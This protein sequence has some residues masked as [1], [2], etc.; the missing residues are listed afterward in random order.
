[1]PV[2]I[3]IGSRY[4]KVAVLEPGDATPQTTYLRHEGR[5]LEVLK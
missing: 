5:P 1:M 4:L 2:G 3:D